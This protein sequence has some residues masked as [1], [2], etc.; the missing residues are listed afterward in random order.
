MK[1]IIFIAVSVAVAVLMAVF[2]DEVSFFG[3]EGTEISLSLIAVFCTVVGAALDSKIGMA[4]AMGIGLAV[5]CVLGCISF[6]MCLLGMLVI[7]TLTEAWPEVKE[8][9]SKLWAPDSK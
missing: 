1:R 3:E 8:M 5:S 2:A 7:V 9:V 4:I 6:A